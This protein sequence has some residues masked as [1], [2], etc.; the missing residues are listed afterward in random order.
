[1]PALLSSAA[2]AVGRLVGVVLAVDR[3][4]KHSEQQQVKYAETKKG[5]CDEQQEQLAAGGS[6][7]SQLVCF[8]GFHALAQ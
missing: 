5:C 8:A 1:M 6:L 4:R 2:D 7:Q 3:M